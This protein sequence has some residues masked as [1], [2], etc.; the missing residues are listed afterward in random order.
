MSIRFGMVVLYVRDLARSATFYRAL[1]LDV[2]DPNP[3]RPVI[4][5]RLA[6]GVTLLLTT[7]ETARRL[8]PSRERSAA[9]AG[10][11]EYQQVTEFFVDDDATVDALWAG[12]PAAGGVQR[13]VP[14]HLLQPYATMI[15]DPDG[16]VL[17]IT[18]EPR[19][20]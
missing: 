14:G 18:S 20:A 19:S 1:G 4:S 16:N 13:R 6:E 2:P 3:D 17:L 5:C 9:A 11:D 8:D 7:D 12:A 10:D 15:D